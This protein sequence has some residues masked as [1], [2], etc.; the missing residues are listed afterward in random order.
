M[1]VAPFFWLPFIIQDRSAA[2]CWCDLKQERSFFTRLFFKC[3]TWNLSS[4]SY[5]NN[6]SKIHTVTHYIF[7]LSDV[8][9][10]ES[11]KQSRW[12]L[13]IARFQMCKSIELEICHEHLPAGKN[14]SQLRLC[15]LTCLQNFC[16]TSCW[17]LWF[18]RDIFQ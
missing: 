1:Q 2:L 14:N 9:S 18:H 11:I 12:I 3:L 16:K 8:K 10:Y 7:V 17:I 4:G 5:G 6:Y 15:V 13:L